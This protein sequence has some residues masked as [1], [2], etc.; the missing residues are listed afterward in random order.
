MKNLFH[1]FAI[2]LALLVPLFSGC[3][4]APRSMEQ[5]EAMEPA[6]YEA[7]AQR[8]EAW[9]EAAG[10]TATEAGADAEKITTYCAYLRAVTDPTG[11][12]L[13]DAATAAG[14]DSP[15]IKLLVLEAQQLLSERGGI[16]PGSRGLELLVRISTS[17]ATGAANGL[18]ARQ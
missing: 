17:V 8:V 3:V 10:Y 15:L 16:P 9:A 6:E 7:W 12:V 14:F 5:L 13:S 4:G 18:A 11:S 1:T 2:A